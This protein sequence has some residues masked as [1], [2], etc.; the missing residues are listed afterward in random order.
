MSILYF[1]IGH[2]EH[3]HHIRR[4]NIP[5]RS[6]RLDFQVIAFHDIPHLSLTQILP[7]HLILT[8]SHPSPY[9]VNYGFA[10]CGHFSKTNAF[11][12]AHQVEA[13]DWQI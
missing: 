11:L 2:R 1:R 5:G 10:G 3:V 13:I 4:L 7:A 9:S 12:Q 6:P 8:T